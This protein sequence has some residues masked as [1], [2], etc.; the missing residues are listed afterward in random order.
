M[1]GATDATARMGRLGIAPLSDEQGL[2]LLDASLAADRSLVVPVRFDT[3]V[4]KPLARAGMLPAF[5]GGVVEV[6]ERRGRVTAS[7]LARRLSSA[8]REE[9]DGLVLEEVRSHVAAAL[10]HESAAAVD[11]D[12]AFTDLG[13]DSLAAVE[14][15]NRL[16]QATGVRLPATLVFDR[17]TPSAVAEWLRSKVEGVERGAPAVAR[18]AVRDEEPIAIVGMGCRYPGG[19]ASPEELW[20]LVAAGTRRDLGVPRRTAAGTWIASTTRTPTTRTPPTRARADSCTTPDEF[21]AGFFG[22]SAAR[23]AGDGPAAAAAA[24]DLL[25]GA[26]GRGHRPAPRCAAADT[27][28]FCGRDVPGL[29]LAARASAQAAEVAGYAMTGTAASVASGRVAYT[30]GLEG[31]A[32]TVDTACSSS[33]VALHLAGQ[34]LRAGR[35]R[36]GA[37]GRRDGDGDTGRVRRVQPPARAGPRR[38]LQVLRGGGRRHGLG[39]G[40]RPA[41]A[42]AAV[43]RAGATATGCSP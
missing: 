40:R 27:G 8:P 36:A 17:P 16:E 19:V 31:P 5:M 9:W 1:G 12:A 25:G 21:D 3:A 10:G 26:R 14:L 33:L 32:V 41:G 15:R 11:P 24:G 2:A 22:I 42:G 13:F 30:L 29:R 38:P 34:A 43:R 23:G 4:L 35:V 28:V 37:G 20:K 18:R 7:P 6:R 39:R